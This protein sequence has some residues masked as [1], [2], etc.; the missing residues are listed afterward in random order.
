MKKIS[1]DKYIF[2]YIKKNERATIGDLYMLDDNY[3]FKQLTKAL[4]YMVDN[5]ILELLSSGEYGIK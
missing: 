5:G 3:T 4:N 1:I 2:N